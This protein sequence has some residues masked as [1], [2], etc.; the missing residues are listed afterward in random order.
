MLPPTVLRRILLLMFLLLSS[1]K[2]MQAFRILA[3]LFNSK[4]NSSFSSSSYSSSSS[5]SSSSA[6]S[7]PSTKTSTPFAPVALPKPSKD[8]LPEPLQKQYG[9]LMEGEQDREN[10]RFSACWRQAMGF[11]SSSCKDMDMP[12]KQRV[13]LHL[14]SCHL[15]EGGRPSVRCADKE[16]DVRVCLKRVQGDAAWATY[17]DL[18]LFADSYCHSLQAD[19]WQAQTEAL[20]N[21]LGQSSRQAVSLL[22]DSADTQRELLEHQQASTRLQED[23]VKA[24]ER[25]QDNLEASSRQFGRLTDEVETGFGA[26]GK[27]YESLLSLQESNLQRQAEL[28]AGLDRANEEVREFTTR[29]EEEFARESQRFN[30]VKNV[31]GQASLVLE[32]A[33]HGWRLAS[34]GVCIA[35]LWTLAP[36]STLVHARKASAW[37]ILLATLLGLL[38]S[39]II[40]AHRLLPTACILSQA[41]ALLDLYVEELGGGFWMMYYVAFFV[42]LLSLWRQVPSPLSS[43]WKAMREWLGRREGEEVGKEEWEDDGRW[44]QRKEEALRAVAE[45]IINAGG[46]VGCGV[47]RGTGGG[48]GGGEGGEGGESCCRMDGGGAAVSLGEAAFSAPEPVVTHI[49][50]PTAETKAVASQHDTVTSRSCSGTSTPLYSSACEYGSSTSIPRRRST[51]LY[52]Q[53][54][55]P[56]GGLRQISRGGGGGGG[57]GRDT[58]HEED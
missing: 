16:K 47:G 56:Y 42:I 58:L 11:L 20:I 49:A 15:E 26:I 1:S 27:Q 50:A 57:F 48:C 39:I 44:S 5:T 3:W 41:L 30:L 24:Q 33:T 54:P 29:M 55:S 7:R 52:S 38:R 13:A 12:T 40:P 18:F 21:H 45:K 14:A 43:L 19:A 17:T 28:L 8:N 10:S 34:I 23:L 4:V 31:L 53:S 9:W 36:S 32:V 46:G 35:A 22:H 37:I 51:R 2:G 6:A 25:L